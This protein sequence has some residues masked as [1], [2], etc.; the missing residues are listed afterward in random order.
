MALWLVYAWD[1]EYRN[2]AESNQEY[3]PS[4]MLVDDLHDSPI[5]L[6][7]FF[8]ELDDS[9]MKKMSKGQE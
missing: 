7:M 6:F 9:T 2:R 5:V 8:S 1:N 4:F 3:H